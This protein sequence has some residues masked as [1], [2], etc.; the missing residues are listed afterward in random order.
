VIITKKP[1][2]KICK[3]LFSK[4]GPELKKRGLGPYSNQYSNTASKEICQ[5]IERKWK[6]NMKN[7]IHK[8]ER[9][10][11]SQNPHVGVVKKNHEQQEDLHQEVLEKFPETL[12]TNSSSSTK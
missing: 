2:K 6:K 9:V 1:K 12:T 10:L 7:K 11:N 5:E 3:T 8:K 4:P